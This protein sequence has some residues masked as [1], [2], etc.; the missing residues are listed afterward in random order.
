M[1]A[2]ITRSVIPLIQRRM[3]DNKAIILY[4]PRQSGKTTLLRQLARDWK[5]PALW[6]NGDDAATRELLARPSRQ[7]LRAV[8]G[9]HRYLVLDEAQRLDNT[10]LLIKIIVDQFPDVK[11]LATGS[12]AFELS[13]QIK[14]PLTGRKWEFYLP[15]FSWAELVQHHN[16]IHEIGALENR[17]RYGMYP[18]IVTHP[19][20]EETLLPALAESYLYKD[21]LMLDGIRKTDRLEKLAQALALQV[22]SEVRYTEL[23][24]LT[25]LD[26]ETVERYILLL[27]RAFILFRLPALSRNVRNE[28]KKS[29]KIYFWDNG[30]RNALVQQF[31]PMNL[32]QDKGAL[33]EN[34][35][36]SERMKIHL[37]QVLKPKSY[38]WRTT[39]QQEIDYVEESAGSFDVFEFKWKENAKARPSLTFV[40]N[41]A[42]RSFATITPRNVE[43]FLLED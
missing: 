39:Q 36:V 38:F 11:V 37:N 19:G 17:L 4:G 23:A 24:G 28:L 26:K 13:D 8:I 34:F 12:S 35:L 41:Y 21:V 3:Q 1:A 20:M 16:Y 9:K 31:G 10:G 5:E 18:E 30:I 25:G 42:M 43:D 6:L 29:R 33:W 2:E 27:E 32:R 22:G 40:N 7:A 14:E 15:P